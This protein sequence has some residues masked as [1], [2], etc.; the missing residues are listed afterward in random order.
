MAGRLTPCCSSLASRSDLSRA[1][2][3]MRPRDRFTRLFAL[4]IQRCARMAG[5]RGG[6]QGLCD[7]R[8]DPRGPG[9]EV[10]AASRRAAAHAG[11]DYESA[12]DSASSTR[13]TRSPVSRTND[14]SLSAYTSFAPLM[15]TIF[16]PVIRI[17]CAEQSTA[18]CRE[19][20]PAASPRTSTRSMAKL[21][22][23]SR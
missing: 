9:G 18:R 21:V 8:R 20:Q 17:S 19:I 4:A 11:R 5:E 6:D 22:V 14:L 12:A 3:T 13:Q 23:S 1:R 15:P 10:A 16:P 7:A 2:G